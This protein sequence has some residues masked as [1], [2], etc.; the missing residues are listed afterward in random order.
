MWMAYLSLNSSL[1][2]LHKIFSTIENIAN[3][4]KKVTNKMKLKK[5]RWE[6]ALNAAGSESN[7][8]YGARQFKITTQLNRLNYHYWKKPINLKIYSGATHHFHKIGSTNLPQQPNSNYNPSERVI[9]P[10]RASMVSS[11]TTNLYITSL[12]SSA[13][14]SHSFNH[15]ASGSLFSVGQ[16]CDHDC[17]AVFDNNSAK[18]LI[19]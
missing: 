12:P 14:K 18:N 2:S 3:I 19:L 17:T 1:I 13:K 6:D 5:I 7:E 9:V 8:S 11:A 15:I 4:R 16:V 10:N